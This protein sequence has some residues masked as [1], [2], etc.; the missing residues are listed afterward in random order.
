MISKI[1]S[2]IEEYIKEIKTANNHNELNSIKINTLGKNGIIKNLLKD[3]L[4]REYDDDVKKNAFDYINKVKQQITQMILKKKTE[5]DDFIQNSKINLEYI[6]VT[7]PV[8]NNNIGTRHILSS[9]IEKIRKY[10][11]FRGFDVVDGPEIDR[12]FYNFDALN[13]KKTHPARQSCDTFYI[14]DD[15]LLRTQTSTMQIRELSKKTLPVK[16][17]SIGR[18][19]RCDSV[20]STHSPIFTQMECLVA[21]RDPICIGNLRHE[22]I[23]FLSFI[24]DNKNIDIRFRTSYFPFVEPGMEVDCLY[25]GSWLEIGG[26]GIVHPNVFSNCGI[27]GKVY[28]FAFGLGIERIVMIKNNINDIRFLYDTDVRI[29]RGLSL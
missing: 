17:V 19:F 13:I 23:N 2:S 9:M 3:V 26:A 14:H 15:W 22:L 1:Q 16:M 6:D 25:N 4:D 20:D 27:D 8:K 11:I 10:F 28:G 12:E 5:I 21:G 24:F 7:L 29:L 18:V